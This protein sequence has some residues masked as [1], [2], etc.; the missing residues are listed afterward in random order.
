LR[1]EARAK[2][3]ASSGL[4]AGDAHPDNF[5]FL[6]FNTTVLYAF[7][8][9]D[10]SGHCPLALD[11]LRYITAVRLYFDAD[12]AETAA[13]RYVKVL[14]GEI[15]EADARQDVDKIRKDFGPDFSARRD[16]KLAELTKHDPLKLLGDDLEK[17]SDATRSTISSAVTKALPGA[18]VLDVAF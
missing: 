17:V 14:N 7:N 10:D 13:K 5:G 16:D 2:I 4:C 11:A 6:K 9:L 1:T 18:K 15:W 12:L 3:P 8:D